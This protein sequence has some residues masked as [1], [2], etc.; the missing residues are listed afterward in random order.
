METQTYILEYISS[1]FASQGKKLSNGDYCIEMADDK[2][3][4]LVVHLYYDTSHKTIE[5]SINKEVMGTFVEFDN[6]GYKF[7]FKQLY[8][9]KI[10]NG[11]TVAEQF[12]EDICNGDDYILLEKAYH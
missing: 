9:E 11:R 5:V 1:I 3:K 7:K 10:R 2:P 6:K 8:R 12:M 4:Y